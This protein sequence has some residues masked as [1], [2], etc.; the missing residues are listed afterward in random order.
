MEVAAHLLQQLPPGKRQD[1][2]DVRRLISAN[3]QALQ[4]VAA[5]RAAPAVTAARAAPAVERYAS[6][7]NRAVLAGRWS[8]ELRSRLEL[9]ERVPAE[10]ILRLMGEVAEVGEQSRQLLAG[11]AAIEA[12]DDVLYGLAHADGKDAADLE[13]TA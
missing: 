2:A 4:A 1:F 6:A 10:E 13:E 11:G 5:A 7:L 9:G 3:E 8:V 12:L